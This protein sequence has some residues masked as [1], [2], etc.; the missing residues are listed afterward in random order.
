[1]L[2]RATIWRRG[3]RELARAFREA[4]EVDVTWALVAFVA[5]L[6][7]P[8]FGWDNGRLSPAAFVLAGATSLPLI[9]RR[10]YPLT[11]LIA[12]TA[13]LLACLAVFHPNI[14][15]VGVL[16]LALYNVGLQGRRLHSLLV[17]AA[18][19]PIVTAAVA[20][21]SSDGLTVG[22]P[23]ARLPLLLL[24]LAAGDARRGRLALVE[25]RVQE[26]EQRHEA[27][28]IHRF[29]EERLRLAHELH[30]TVGHALVGIN[31]Q[32]AAA[33]H[34][35]RRRQPD[36]NLGA[37]EDIVRSSADALGELRSTLK[38]IRASAEDAPMHPAQSLTDLPGLIEG[39]RGSGVDVQV[40]LGLNPVPDDLPPAI[41][42]AAYRI[43]QESLTNV[44]RHSSAKRAVVRVTVVADRLTV[45]VLDDGEASPRESTAPGQGV[46]GMSERAAA[47][48][49]HCEAGVAPG[50]GWVVRASLP[51]T[52]AHP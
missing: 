48:G 28:A 9:V 1:M 52:T 38:L 11:A 10:R 14:A 24:A 32:A 47:L 21:T 22:T 39:V 2:N 7:D 40:D 43:V 30:D 20:I 16:M 12:V 13:G 17:G 31:V 8:G 36:D 51:A 50:G 35:R 3:A 19:A 5:L 37:L 27:A 25:A 33:V 42:H 34:L 29:D 23:L 49:G 15:A 18:M 44:L 41:A 6:A 45:E 4:P 26:A 46:P